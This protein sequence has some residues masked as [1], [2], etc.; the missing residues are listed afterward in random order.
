[1]KMIATVNITLSVQCHSTWGDDC[2]MSQVKKQAKEEAMSLATRA[3]RSDPL[4]SNI[5]PG[6]ISITLTD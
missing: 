4:V 1:M 3:L 5:T 2:T 6:K